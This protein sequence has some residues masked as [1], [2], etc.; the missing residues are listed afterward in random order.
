MS[1]GARGNNGVLF[2]T[3]VSM[4]RETKAASYPI[5]RILGLVE[6]V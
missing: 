1:H 6:N 2:G 4:K 3:H 5:R